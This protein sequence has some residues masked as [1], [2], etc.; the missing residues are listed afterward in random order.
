M[1]QFIIKTLISALI[2]A[3][4]STLSKKAP[5]FGAIIVSLPLTSILALIWLYVD[6]KDTSKLIDLSN[7]ITLMV[8]P[9]IV[10][11]IALSILLKNHIK[12]HYSLILSSLIMIVSYSI[13]NFILSKLGI[14]I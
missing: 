10:F 12:V 3:A 2:I 14:K 4:V 7:S 5:L 13:Y 6:T 1:T 11:F 9:S 8:V